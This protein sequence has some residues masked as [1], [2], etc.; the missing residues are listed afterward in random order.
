M[1]SIVG[2]AQ[3][4]AWLLR[5]PS[6][7]SRYTGPA[8]RSAGSV[9]G[10]QLASALDRA[11]TSSGRSIRW[12]HSMVRSILPRFMWPSDGHDA[13]DMGSCGCVAQALGAA[14][15]LLALVTHGFL[16]AIDNPD[17]WQGI[18]DPNEH[19]LTLVS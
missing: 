1:N 11:R 12:R 7:L 2:L 9:F 18:T 5:L 6:A 13:Q 19:P 4:L 3:A 8:G 15:L 14:L 10:P 17:R 16:L